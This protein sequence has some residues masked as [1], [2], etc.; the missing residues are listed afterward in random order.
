MQ[1]ALVGRDAAVPVAVAV[2]VKLPAAADGCSMQPW[3]R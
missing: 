2:A 1:Y 3:H